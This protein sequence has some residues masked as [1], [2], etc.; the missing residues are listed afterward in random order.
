MLLQL[1]LLAKWG[2]KENPVLADIVIIVQSHQRNTAMFGSQ[3][4]GAKVYAQVGMETDVN[5][6]SAH[7]LIVLLF[8]GAL[9]ALAQARRSMQDN[10]IA[11]KGK[12]ISKAIQIIDSGLRASLD[13]KVGG[14]IAQ[15]LDS[16]YGYMGQRLLIASLRN[17]PEIL[18]EVCGLLTELK[19]AWVL[20]SPV[21]QAITATAMPVTQQAAATKIGL[22]HSNVATA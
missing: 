13:K 18:D 9:H 3:A 8:D 17:G 4:R 16:L 21:N 6:A 11:T 14:Q 10:D 15:T 19:G 2:H 7:Q 22:Y 20:I 1:Q 12:A 5:G